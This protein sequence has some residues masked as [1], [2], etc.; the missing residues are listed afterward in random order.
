MK[1]AF[2]FMLVYRFRLATRLASPRLSGRF[3]RSARARRKRP[4]LP[5]KG[6][7]AS[8]PPRAQPQPQSPLGVLPL[9]PLIHL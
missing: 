2:L 7:T 8:P 4:M 3:S 6:H 1:K 5:S 9:P